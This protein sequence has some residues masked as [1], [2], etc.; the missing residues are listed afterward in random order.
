MSWVIQSSPRFKV[1]EPLLEL[2][3]GDK[4]RASP[5]LRQ[6]LDD[7]LQRYPT[8]NVRNS[9]VPVRDN[10]GTIVDITEKGTYVV[11]FEGLAETWTLRAEGMEPA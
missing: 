6:G 4:V 2:R 5:S 8:L 11:K 7:V 1:F 3:V 9:F 10:V